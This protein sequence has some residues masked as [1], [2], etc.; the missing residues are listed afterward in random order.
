MEESGWKNPLSRGFLPAHKE[1]RQEC[2]RFRSSAAGDVKAAQSHLKPPKATA[3][4]YSRHI[5]GIDSG[6]QSHTKA[7]PRLHQGYTKATPRLHQG[8]PTA[9]LKPDTCEVLDR[10]R[11]WEREEDRGSLE[12]WNSRFMPASGLCT[13]STSSAGRSCR[14]SAPRHL[15]PASEPSRRDVR[16]VSER[17]AR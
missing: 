6:V 16:I 4:P 3:K 8:Y 17:I 14:R 13:N 5:L 10:A 1:S 9:S 2:P 7:T 12:L 11:R 15:L